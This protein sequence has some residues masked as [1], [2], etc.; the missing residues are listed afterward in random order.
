MYKTLYLISASRYTQSLKSNNVN[1]NYSYLQLIV[2]P[3]GKGSK[4]KLQLHGSINYWY[5]QLYG[6]L[7]NKQ[8]SHMFCS[9]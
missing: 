2:T 8:V 3:K 5:I 1:Y 4:S 6:Q 7:L 9:Y